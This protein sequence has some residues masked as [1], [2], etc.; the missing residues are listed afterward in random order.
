MFPRGGQVYLR[1]GL[2]CRDVEELLAERGVDVDR[3]S[4]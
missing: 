3:V 4:V 2:F 1:Y